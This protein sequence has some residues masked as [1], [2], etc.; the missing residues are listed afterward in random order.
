[1]GYFWFY[2]SIPVGIHHPSGDI[3]KI[4]F[5]YNNASNS[6]NYWDVNNWEDGTTEPGSQVLL[7]LMV[8]LNELLVNSMEVLL[9]VLQSLMIHMERHQLLGI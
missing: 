2:T 4:S 6:G 7:F 1:M 3:K 8:L 9:H 5:D